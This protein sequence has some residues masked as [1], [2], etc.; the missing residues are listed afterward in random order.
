M[1]I[2]VD[3]GQH[4]SGEKSQEDTRRDKHL[5]KLGL[6]FLRF[7]DSDVLLNIEGVIENILENIRVRE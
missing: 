7:S 1:V 5:N 4:Y 2:E 3:G 6:K